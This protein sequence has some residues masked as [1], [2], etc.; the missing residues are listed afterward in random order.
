MSLLTLDSVT[1]GYDGIPTVKNVSFSV[2][3]GDFISVLGK[4]GTGK[5]TLIKGILGLLSPI[6]GNIDCKIERRKIGYL[7]QK[8]YVAP[9]FPATV[10]EVIE[11]S[12]VQGFFFS[13]RKQRK[14]DVLGAAELCNVEG[15]LKMPFCGLSVGQQQ[16]ALI[17]R[18]ICAG[19]EL[20]ILD[21]PIA[22]LDAIAAGEIYDIL[23]E[24]RQCGSS[25]IMISHDLPNA[26][27]FSNKILHMDHT[28]EFFGSVEEY[29][30]TRFYSE[31]G[32]IE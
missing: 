10:E 15:L 1:L 11:S 18:A 20:I 23:D 19:A 5:S 30:V 6:S 7:P 13:D 4:N 32:G 25:I 28:S 9:F 14:K 2:D 31:W 16:R 26:M 3:K 12:I 29:K 21:E 17:A 27:K 24:M 8:C 22:S